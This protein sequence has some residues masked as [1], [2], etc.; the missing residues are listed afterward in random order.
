MMAPNITRSA[1]SEEESTSSNSGSMKRRFRLMAASPGYIM[2][3]MSVPRRVFLAI[4]LACLPGAA[5]AAHDN[6]E[7]DPALKRHAGQVIALGA[8]DAQGRV[9]SF[10]LRRL[11]A[12]APFTPDE[13]RGW[14]L[15]MLAGKRFA[16]VFEVAANG[17]LEITVSPLDGP[18]EGI[19]VK[20][21]F[22]VENI[23]VERRAAAK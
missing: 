6:I 7:V 17:G 22:V 13:L 1:T 4:A 23:A 20:D 2:Q 11:P 21:V 12:A 10:Q 3:R 16:H 18:L 14:R 19:A 8:P 15:T 9:Y 5:R